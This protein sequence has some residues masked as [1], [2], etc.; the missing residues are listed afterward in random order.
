MFHAVSRHSGRMPVFLF[1][2]GDGGGFEFGGGGP[3]SALR[4]ILVVQRRDESVEGIDS[5]RCEVNR[6]DPIKPQM[7]LFRQQIG[8]KRF[9]LLEF[10][11][12]GDDF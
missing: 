10:G 8:D 7:E 12:C 11:F 4:F 1:A 6:K 9:L 3:G 2:A 5:I